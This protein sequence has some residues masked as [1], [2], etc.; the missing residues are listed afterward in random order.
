[1]IEILD[2]SFH[3]DRAG[4]LSAE[5]AA[6]WDLAVTTCSAMRCN[7]IVGQSVDTP[8]QVVTST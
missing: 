7:H 4:D 5:Q 3:E 2:R 1:M 8:Q 6:A